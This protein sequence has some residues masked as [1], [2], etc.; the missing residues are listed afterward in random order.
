M[1]QTAILVKEKGEVTMDK[2]FDFLCSQLRNGRY[3]VTI[4]RYTEPRTLNQNA[5]MWM[6]FTCIEHE[7]GTPKQDVHDYY[8][9]LFLRRTAVI[10]GRETVIAGSTSKLNTL[11]MTDFLNKV[12]ADAATELGITLPLPQDRFYQEFINEYKYRR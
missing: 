6:W 4:E 10:K 8:C 1:S 12:K 7:T 5:L 9:N 3:R 2:S 11:Q